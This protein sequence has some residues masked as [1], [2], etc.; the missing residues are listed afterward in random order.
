MAG[1][2]WLHLSDWHQQVQKDGSFDRRVVRDAL[3]N[4]IKERHKIHQDLA[5]VDFIV[6]SGDVAFSG[7][8]NEYQ[9]AVS[10][11]FEPVLDAAGLDKDRL[12][13]VPGNHD[14]DRD[15]FNLLPEPLKNPLMDCN[16]IKI[17]LTESKKLD[18]LLSIFAP[19]NEFV[20][21]Y[22]GGALSAY[23]NY[24]ELTIN[25]KKVVLMGFNSA[26]MCGRDKTDYGN[27]FIGEPQIYEVL[28]N[29]KG[30][31]VRI[32]VMHHPLEYLVNADLTTVGGRLKKNVHFILCGHQHRGTVTIQKSTE[33]D[34]VIIPAGA[35][36][37]RRLE[38]D[39]LYT[40]AYNFVHLDFESN[41]GAAYLRQWS[42]E[43]F[44]WTCH[45]RK[46]HPDGTYAFS[47]P[48]DLIS[49][50]EKAATL[51]SIPGLT[52]VPAPFDPD[53][54]VFNVP[55][56]AKNEGMVGREEALQK[57]RQQLLAGRRT[58]IGH[59][60][61][62]QGLGGLGKTQLA[63]E[64]AYRFRNEYPYGVIWLNADQDMDAQL[65]QIAKQ[66][67]WIAPESKQSDILDVAIQRLKSRSQC[68]VIFD[69][70]VNRENIEP[71]LPDAEAEPHL[72]VTSRTSQKDFVPIPIDLLDN[73]LSLQLLL[74]EAGRNIEDLTMEEQTAAR[75]IAVS[76]DGLP[77]AIGIAGAYLTCVPDFTFQNYKAVLDDSFEKALAGDLLSSF[78][79]HE[80]NLFVT[81]QVS[82][83]V[84]NQ[85][86]LLQDILDLLA[87]SGSAFMGISLMAAIL[88][89]KGPELVH[90][91][92]LGTSLR[93]LHKAPGGDRYDIHRLVRKVRQ[94]QFPITDKAQWVM[95]V[96]QRLGHWFEEKRKEFTALPVFEAEFNHLKEWLK[97]ISHYTSIHTVRLTWLQAS[98]LIHWGKYHEAHQLVQSAF[99]LLETLPDPDQPLKANILNDLGFTYGA[100]GN[101]E[102]SLRYHKQALDIQIEQFGEQHR[103]TAQSLNN[104]GV[105]YGDL[106]NHDEAL[107]YLTRAL[108]IRL[109]LCGE[110][111][112]DTAQSFNNVGGTYGALR[113]HEEALKYKERALN[114]RLK[115]FGE[116]HPATARSLDSI[117]DIYFYLGKY[118][119]A[120][121]YIKQ[122]FDIRF[123]ILGEYHPDTAKTFCDLVD[124]LM[125]LRKFNEAAERLNGYLKNLPPGHSK[126]E[127]LSALL[128]Q[129]NQES[130]NDRVQTAVGK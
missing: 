92:S 23:A 38:N 49:E 60:A 10:Y 122:A 15:D 73:E 128:V 67:R 31:D 119:E 101:H 124:C 25:G 116:Q 71:Y 13:I 80:Q 46:A 33:G 2:T 58:A 56:R 97:H 108:N 50:E 125:K 7:K 64:Y 123:Q 95:E 42:E 37:H 32:A 43:D 16:E 6:F 100:L 66:A 98:P 47:L 52:S 118:G 96:C 8:E 89:K 74:K 59:T 72:L 40:N 21:P 82:Q 93:L 57:V 26:L 53:N 109:E 83:P 120:L 75:E 24:Y 45:R 90:P 103:D 44:K 69:N 30:A 126:Y 41:T 104:V 36:Y 39:P 79:G 14:L 85:A 111:H 94:G 28:E 106:E 130:V 63:V 86:P 68:L 117:G 78:T 81:L 84:L 87:W 115:L 19:Y 17:W 9:A 102:E 129:I 114:I 12:F 20:K 34:C 48:K 112:P 110:Q 51:P 113:N 62:L 121:N 61:A 99:S 105:T 65:I 88:D 5:K 70:V 27:L 55:Y 11:F 3:I 77:L 76:L 22:A 54:T 127:K 91:L 29:A 35:A 1:L 18:R 107:K 4:D